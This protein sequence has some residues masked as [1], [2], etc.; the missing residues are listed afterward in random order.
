MATDITRLASITATS[1]RRTGNRFGSNQL[2]TQV[3]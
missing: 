1:I 3:V 2:V